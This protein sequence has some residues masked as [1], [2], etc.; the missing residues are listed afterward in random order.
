M[1]SDVV[2]E[3]LFISLSR[4]IKKKS[5]VKTKQVCLPFRDSHRNRA[6]STESRAQR[7]TN[8]QWLETIIATYSHTRID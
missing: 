2:E 5:N 7:R 4:A 6:Q 3:V 1:S 8:N